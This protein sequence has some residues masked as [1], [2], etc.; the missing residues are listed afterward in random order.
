ML[1]IETRRQLVQDWIIALRSGLYT[2]TTE[3]LRRSIIEEGTCKVGHCCL[4]VLC[5]L[6]VHNGLIPEAK[7]DGDCF[8]TPNPDFD[9][10]NDEDDFFGRLLTD[11]SELPVLVR[12]LIP[13]LKCME[14]SELINM[15]DDQRLTFEQIANYLEQT[16]LPKLTLKANLRVNFLEDINDNALG[17][18]GV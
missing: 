10:E 18:H 7:W 15:N 6:V 13:E 9:E 8:V 16:I 2:Q 3:V 17:I 11:E 12:R 5:E 1:P 4:G 14:E